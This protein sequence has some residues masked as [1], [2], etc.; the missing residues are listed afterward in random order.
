MTN[1]S[2]QDILP[3]QVRNSKQYGLITIT[4]IR[5]G[6]ENR[7]PFCITGKSSDNTCITWTY[8]GKLSTRDIMQ[9]LT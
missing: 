8:D 1:L 3:G 7:N 4:N 6:Q 2:I 9:D 5:Y